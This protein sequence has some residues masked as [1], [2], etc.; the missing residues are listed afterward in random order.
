MVQKIS[1]S[2]RINEKFLN[3]LFSK[4]GCK[5]N[6][7]I[8]NNYSKPLND[9]QKYFDSIYYDWM[10]VINDK[11][12]NKYKDHS[13]VQKIINR[14]DIPSAQKLHL[15]YNYV[16][17]IEKVKFDEEYKV[18]YEYFEHF[19]PKKKFE[20]LYKMYQ[21]NSEIETILNDK[22]IR[23]D[24]KTKLILIT[25]YKILVEEFKRNPSFEKL[26]L[27]LG[28]RI[29]DEF[30]KAD[31]FFKNKF[32]YSGSLSYTKFIQDTIAKHRTDKVIKEIFENKGISNN[33]KFMLSIIYLR[34][35]LDVPTTKNIEESIKESI[36]KL[37]SFSVYIPYLFNKEQI[38]D[39]LNA[40]YSDA[41]Q[42]FSNK[43][44][45]NQTEKIDNLIA[46]YKD[47]PNIKGIID[48]KQLL[49]SLKQIDEE[50]SKAINSMKKLITEYYSVISINR[51]IEDNINRYSE[52]IQKLLNEKKYKYKG[53]DMYRISL[54]PEI[55]KIIKAYTIYRGEIQRIK[56][57]KTS[58]EKAKNDAEEALRKAY[59][60]E[61]S[62]LYEENLDNAYK[63][64]II[65]FEI[66]YPN[67]QYER[68]KRFSKLENDYFNQL[69]YT[70][71]NGIMVN[72]YFYKDLETNPTHLEKAKL[73]FLYQ[74]E[75]EDKIINYN[76]DVAMKYF[77]SR[78]PDTF[79][80]K[81]NE[82]RNKYNSNFA[83]TDRYYDDYY[84]PN[85]ELKEKYKIY[86]YYLYDDYNNFWDIWRKI[87][88]FLDY[89]GSIFFYLLDRI[90]LQWIYR[91][92]DGYKYIVDMKWAWWYV[93][94]YKRGTVTSPS[95]ETERLLKANT[96]AL[97]ALRGDNDRIALIL[98]NIARRDNQFR[99][100]VNNINTGLNNL[101]NSYNNS[102]RYFKNLVNRSGAFVNFISEK[103]NSISES[104]RDLKNKITDIQEGTVRIEQIDN[105]Q[106]VITNLTKSMAN[107]SG[108]IENSQNISRDSDVIPPFTPRRSVVPNSPPESDSSF[109]ISPQ[110]SPEIPRYKEEIS[111]STI[112]DS[113]LT[114]DEIAAMTMNP[115][116]FN[117]YMKTKKK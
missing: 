49:V 22:T 60:I 86:K 76:Y 5:C 7:G 56:N 81:I 58:T 25:M 104:C 41:L 51:L 17:E 30:T 40:D 31:E 114:D 80:A 14:N 3:K 47:H 38:K 15:L 73:I 117:E 69:V 75:L 21:T 83:I 72:N 54:D 39:K 50:E 105:L 4:D 71:S 6:D 84:Y 88:G 97:I 8:G 23:S 61:Q 99:I 110:S 108:I 100:A 101:N 9:V 91:L 78:Y 90:L 109:N 2:N 33:T 92:Y 13:E 102:Q 59:E 28:N 46:R 20:E 27:Q 16:Y 29:E 74:K 68:N 32:K 98:D 53:F 45:L 36:D 26:Y 111:E 70:I 89:Y 1:P 10:N 93:P 96:D 12:R 115:L 11:L 87:K 43:Y 113:E 107:L 48:V 65:Y 94:K 55:E 85:Q 64:A 66:T 106:N 44:S 116:M 79:D 82:L 112:K 24:Y 18:A 67:T 77:R 35:I 62:K 63:K 52:H 19:F 57:E 103:L 95:T 42:Y 34:Y 37:S